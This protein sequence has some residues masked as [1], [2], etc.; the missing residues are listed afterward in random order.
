MGSSS[1]SLAQMH[2]SQA[3]G[4]ATNR[5]MNQGDEYAGPFVCPCIGQPPKCDVAHTFLP[6][7]PSR[8][9]MATS[10]WRHAP[11]PSREVAIM[12]SMSLGIATALA[13][14]SIASPVSADMVTVTYTGTVHDG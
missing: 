4:K 2:K 10:I 6:I 9:G 14:F 5:Q 13:F 7:R 11:F 8:S 3:V 1:K 12:K